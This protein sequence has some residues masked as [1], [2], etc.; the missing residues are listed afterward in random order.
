MMSYSNSFSLCRKSNKPY[1]PKHHSS[2]EGIR[3]VNVVKKFFGSDESDAAVD[4]S[5]PLTHGEIMVVMT[6]IMITVFLGALDQTIVSTALPVIARDLHGLNEYSWVATAYLLTSAIAT[7]IFGKISDMYGRKKIFQLSIVIFLI[8]SALSGAAQTMHQLIFFRALQG[9]GGGALMSLSLA[10]IGDTV[11]P[12]DRGRYQG[13]IGAVF[14]ISSVLGPLLGGLFT[15]HLSWRWVFYINIPIGLVALSMIATRL[16]LPINR[17]PHKI[18]WTGAGLLSA[19][20]VSLLLGTVWG[21]VQYPWGSWQIISLFAASLVFAGLFIWREHYAA[22]PII[23]LNLFKNDVIRTSA[24]LSFVFGIAM[25]GALIFLP[26][27][28]QLVRGDSATK[29]GLMMLP[30]VVGMMTGSIGGG[31]L[32]SKIGKYRMFPIIGSLVVMSSF[33]MFSQISI[34][35][36]RAL[37][38]IWMAL[39]GL[40]LGL[41]MPVMTLAVQNAV[42][43]RQMGTATSVVTFFRG[44]GSSLGAAIFGA[45][46]LN[47][48]NHHL[49][50]SLPAGANTG[51]EVASKNIDNLS[52]LP[53]DVLHTVLNAFAQ[54]F[55]DVFLFA[56]PVTIVAFIIALFLRDIPLKQ[57]HDDMPAPVE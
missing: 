48:L 1:K 8:G 5:K 37:I 57:S 32:I 44:I 33:V 29:S 38:A 4:H 10:V 3:G 7:P 51:V 22:E 13:L 9:I 35:T 12:R 19:G 43:R 25:F 11:P 54:S 42:D 50:D 34:D 27:Y 26:Q 40:G 21:G 23:P 53:P 45:I 49:A 17:S 18:D 47:R 2:E 14:G 39:L 56:I 41:I 28:Q 55:G 30:L 31:R 20:V 6:A 15:D 46:L 36:N 16:H 24:L 52:A